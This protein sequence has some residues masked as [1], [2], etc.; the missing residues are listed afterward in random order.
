MQRQRAVIAAIEFQP[1]QPLVQQ[2]ADHF[3]QVIGL[4]H[5]QP[6]TRLPPIR[7][8]TSLLSVGKSTVVDALDRLRAAG[9][10]ASRQGAGHYVTRDALATQIHVARDLLPQDTLSVLRHALLLDNGSLR[11]GCGFLPS[12]WLPTDD[13]MKAMRGTLRATS[14]RMGEYGAAAGY[15]PLRQWL[16]VK[17]NTLGIDVPVEQ[18]VTTA[19]TVHG[20]DML[21]R[22][23]LARGDR[24]LVDDPCYFNFRANL[25]YHGATPVAVARSVDGVDF[26][27]L[28]HLLITQR[29]KVYLTNSALHNPTGHSFSAAQVYRLLE[30][31]HRY[32]VHIIEDDLYCDIQHKRTPRLAAAGGLKSVSYISGFSKTLTANSRVSYAVLNA[33]LAGRMTSLK[34]TSGGVTS[35]LTEQ[36]IHRM[37]SEGSYERHTRRIVDRLCESSARVASWLRESGCEVAS[38]Q[39]E[40]LF[41]WTQLPT[42]VDAQALARQGLQH[43]LVLAPGALLSTQADAW[44]YMRFNVGHSDSQVVRNSFFRLLDSQ[45]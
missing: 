3:T 9:L 39:G 41:L 32:G 17:L 27:A 15:L 40:G 45:A 23:L 34:M 16:R 43:E 24:V 6:G 18:I 11:P 35:E 12:S 7:E 21:L 33:E 26:D 42:G 28:E 22:M 10:V 19:N 36:I 38:K 4:G 8:L 37:L 44:R 31:C 1:G 29:P 2:I 13:L 5:L 14:L 20:I 25:A 30:L